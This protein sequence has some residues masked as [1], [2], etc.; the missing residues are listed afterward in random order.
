MLTSG[1]AG[2]DTCR[3]LECG[4]DDYL[5]AP[6]SGG[7]LLARVAL[8]VRRFRGGSIKTGGTATITVDSGQ[9]CVR[10]RGLPVSLTP[11]EYSLAST[12]IGRQGRPTT[13]Q[14]AR[15]AV[16]GTEQGGSA[17]A[18]GV[19]VRNL[20]KK[21]ELQPDRPRFLMSEPG[22]GYRWLPSGT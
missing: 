3:L 11:H 4:A 12:L 7:L 6:Y 19:L 17:K 14:M 13:L 9:Q 5:A 2:P 15:M 8:A 1:K 10:R 16:W 18:V 21:L 22:I 20:R